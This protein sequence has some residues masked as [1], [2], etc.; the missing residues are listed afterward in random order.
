ML[1][2]RCTAKRVALNTVAIV[3][4][5]MFLDSRRLYGASL[6][7]TAAL[8]GDDEKPISMAQPLH[9]EL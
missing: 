4:N 3:T 2:G 9:M 7:H 1:A 8:V 5:I 6:Y